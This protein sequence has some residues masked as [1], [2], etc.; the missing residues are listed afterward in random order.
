M[1]SIGSTRPRHLWLG[2][3]NGLYWLDKADYTIR[4]LVPE[5]WEGERINQL[6]PTEEGFIVQSRTRITRTDH[7]GAPLKE[8][9]RVDQEGNEIGIFGSAVYQGKVFASFNDRTLF[10]IDLA[11]DSLRQIDL[12]AGSDWI[13]YL[14]TDK[15][16]DGLW[17]LDASG[18]VIHLEVKD[19]EFHFD[20]YPCDSPIGWWTYTLKQSPYDGIIWILNTVGLKAY[21]REEGK[22]LTMVYSSLEETPKYHMLASVWCDSLYT[23][24]A[25]FDCCVPRPTP[26]TISHY[27]LYPLE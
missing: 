1:D 11:C 7:Q 14:D 3:D 22:R 16:E 13:T 24:V 6:L 5:R 17:L 9:Y 27:S 10:C 12:P 2:S 21:R 25:A 19:E 23:M 20:S 18:D 8:Y 4:A 15:Q 26:S